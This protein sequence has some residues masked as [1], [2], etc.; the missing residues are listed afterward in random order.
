MPL[1][2]MQ[3]IQKPLIQKLLRI[4]LTIVLGMSIM[5][6][7]G[8][9]TDADKSTVENAPKKSAN[10]ESPRL[11]T[12]TADQ[13]RSILAFV[14]THDSKLHGLLGELKSSR[15]VAY[16]R[17]LVDLNRT[18]ER[19][20]QIKRNRPHAYDLELK[21]WQAQSKVQIMS[22]RLAVAANPEARTQ[23]RQAIQEQADLR[24]AILKADREATAK[25]LEQIDEQI[26]A[27]ESQKS[28]RVQQEF[29]RFV[30]AARRARSA[31]GNASKKRPD[32]KIADPSAGEPPA[33]SSKTKE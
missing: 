28:D 33:A 9:Q 6:A 8:A 15:P 4:S 30:A 3:L 17:A 31:Q 5:S 26:A 32:E 12:V 7:A 20:A 22:A 16:Q 1:M 14:S 29:D 11:A 25:R 10:R 2:Q 24:L 13:E 18:T 27:A 23:L 21:R 19:L